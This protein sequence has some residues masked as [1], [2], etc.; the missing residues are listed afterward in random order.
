MKINK[1]RKQKHVQNLD[2]KNMKTLAKMYHT[3]DPKSRKNKKSINFK[4]IRKGI[5]GPEM[6][7][8][9]PG[10]GPGM[11]RGTV[12]PNILIDIYIYIFIHIPL[13]NSDADI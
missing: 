2:A 11:A 3:R 6:E 7:V 4:F 12:G 10:P 13:K 8:P 9:L 5:P 1:T